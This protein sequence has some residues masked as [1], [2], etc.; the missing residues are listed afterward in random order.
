MKWLGILGLVALSQ[1]LVIIPLM[2]IKTMRETLREENLLTNFLEDN[3]DH[4]FQDAS[5]DPNIS[6]QPLRN[7]QDLCYVGNITIGTPPQEFRVVFDT[8]SSFTWMPSI[9]CSSIS[10]RTHNLFNPQLSTTFQPSVLSFDLE[11]GAGRIVGILAYDTIRIMNLVDLDQAFG[12]SVNQSGL[13]HAVFDGVLGLGYPSL[14]PK[15]ITPVFDNLK[16]RGVISQ[17]IFAFYLSSR[18]ENGSVGMFGGVD[19]SYHKGQLKRIPVT[20]TLYWQI[21]VN[22]I[23]VNGKFVGCYRGCQ[24]I[25]DT[26]T[27]FLACPTRSVTTIQKLINATPFSEEYWVPCSNITN[28]PAIIFNING[29]D[30][31]VPAEAYIWKCPHSTGIS[32][33]QGGTE[34]WNVLETWVLGEAFLRLYF[35]L[36][37]RG[38]NRVGLASAV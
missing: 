27:A 12:L 30:Y 9:N 33:F 25:L 11:Y 19:H 18:K 20:R 28:L 13:D 23:T 32:W 35:S 22:N 14:T 21:A 8:T 24:A 1:C 31:P 38:N 36:Y 5:A 26:G 2:K 34:T 15:I 37:D 4:R 17:H 3:T 29:T 16:K 6:L 10:C 7:Y